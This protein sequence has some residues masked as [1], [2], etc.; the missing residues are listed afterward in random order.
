VVQ[1]SFTTVL[2]PYPLFLEKNRNCRT[3]EK[4][5]LR[6]SPLERIGIMFS[7]PF[8]YSDIVPCSK[9]RKRRGQIILGENGPG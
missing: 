9:I 8:Y 4:E 5:E 3:N 7:L 1:Q 6:R 2:L